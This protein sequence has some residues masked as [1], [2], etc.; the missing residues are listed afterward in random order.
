[1]GGWALLILVVTSVPP[2]GGAAPDR[3]LLLFGVLEAD[4][5]VHAAMYAVLGWLTVAALAAAEF[6]PPRRLV[7]GLAAAAAF[8]ALDEWHQVW[9]PWRSPEVMDWVAD[10]VGLAVG[11]ATRTVLDGIGTDAN[12][13]RGGL[14]STREEGATG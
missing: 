10:A 6:A 11:A 1:M 3:P 13:D 8:A 5:V 14:G 9:I 7:A 4:K 12:R 2:P